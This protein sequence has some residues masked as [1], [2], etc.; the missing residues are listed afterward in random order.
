MELK[1]LVRYTTI[2]TS[3]A[4]LAACSSADSGTAAT[5]LTPST[6]TAVTISGSIFASSVNSA[7]VTVKNSN[8]DTVA[9]PVMTATDGTYSVDVLDTDLATDLVFES[10]G[11][12]F[13]DEA[14]GDV[15]VQAG[16]MSAFVDGGTLAS[17]DSVHVTPGTTI[18][19]ALVIQHNK[20]VSEAETTFFNAFAYNP[21]ISIEPVDVTDASSIT[22]DDASKHIGWRAAVFSKLAMDLLL[23]PAQQFD[24]FAA[25]AQDLSDSQLDGVD[26][27]GAVDIGSTGTTLPADILNKYIKATG[28]FTTAEAANLVVTYTPPTENVHG[29]NQFTLTITDTGGT[30]VT[31]LTDLQVMPMMYMADRTHATPMGGITELGNGEYEVTAYYLMPSRMQMNTITMGTWDLKVMTNMKSVHFYP[32]I[33]M[34]MMTNTVRTEPPLKG[35]SDT[36]FN[37]DGLEVG[38]PYNLFRDDLIDLGAGTTYD[39]DIFIA[40]METMMS[41]PALIVGE[42]LQSGMGGTPYTVNN[43]DVD[44]NVNN[45]G[46]LT[47]KDTDNLDGTWNLKALPL[48][49][50]GTNEIRVRL[51]VNGEIKTTDELPAQTDVNDFVTFTVTLP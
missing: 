48:D 26:A 21:D 28:S 35:V 32:N 18:I 22:A 34:A 9:G 51:T 25:L 17:G 29:K 24:M 15:G 38:R 14:T 16:A 49:N 46:W 37:M 20:S 13:D 6:P 31:G 42:T 33:E 1:S 50:P 23:T 2:L 5:P 47:N 30:P 36:I 27:S 7:T 43:V 40:P 44:V 41:F 19:A 12:L 4:V 10:T 45:G 39:F 8:G 3:I 11:G